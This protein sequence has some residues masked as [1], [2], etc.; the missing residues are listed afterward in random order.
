M[1][2][3]ILLFIPAYNCE[4]HLPLVM[5]QLKSQWIE[6]SI[7]RIIIIENC[8]SDRTIDVAIKEAKDKPGF[9]E[10]LQNDENY[11]LGGSHKVAFNYAKKNGFEWVAVL[12]GDNQGDIG[13]FKC[14]L[15]NK[16]YCGFDII[17]GARF[18]PKSNLI[19]YSRI[20]IVGNYL[21][22]FYYSILL[23]KRVYDL[24]SGLNLLRV[25]TLP[26]NIEMAPDDL[27]FNCV[28]LGL[29]INRKLRIKFLPISWRE[30]GQI[31][32]VKIFSQSLKMLKIP[33]FIIRSKILN[34]PQDYRTTKKI[35]S[36]KRII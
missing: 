19:G 33:I 18:M 27:T 34:I 3:N 1:L 2:N 32:N 10:V 4:N 8:G 22:N 23:G 24:G 35:Y 14:C 26:P 6:K 20:R 21:F 29:A 30:D 16:H 11:G 12:H 15:E 36:A 28:L 17:L 25:S 13:D 5:N 7:R 31:S 9:I